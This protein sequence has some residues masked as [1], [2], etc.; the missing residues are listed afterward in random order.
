M[1]RILLGT[2]VAITRGSLGGFVD[3]HTTV[4]LRLSGEEGH[5]DV[6]LVMPREQARGI[7]TGD[8]FHVQVRGAE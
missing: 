1:T 7:A 2:V 3:S 6:F 4:C 5:G 8:E